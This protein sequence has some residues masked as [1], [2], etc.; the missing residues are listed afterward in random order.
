MD[1]CEIPHEELP[2]LQVSVAS[3]EIQPANSVFEFPKWV[4][5]WKVHTDVT[6]GKPNGICDIKDLLL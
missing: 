5:D 2:D 4:G 1:G 3:T 6:S